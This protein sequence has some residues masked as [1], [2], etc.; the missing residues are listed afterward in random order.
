MTALRPADR[1]AREP[2]GV[3]ALR[4][5]SQP[6]SEPADVTTPRP[7][8]T[9][10]RG[11]PDDAELAA[12]TVVLLALAA[13]A[14]SEAAAAVDRGRVSWHVPARFAPPGSWTSR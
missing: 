1:Q 2:A 9:V 10:L 7:L 6:A 4:P 8:F 11:E 14:A 12:V 13:E 3:T 5:A